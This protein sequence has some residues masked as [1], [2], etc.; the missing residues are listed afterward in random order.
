MIKVASILLPFFICNFSIL[1]AID[2][3]KNRFEWENV[4]NQISNEQKDKLEKCAEYLIKKDTLGYV[5]FGNKPV[6]MAGFFDPLTSHHSMFSPNIK[7]TVMT[8]IMIDILEEANLIGN[9]PNSNFLIQVQYKKFQDKKNTYSYVLFINKKAFIATVNKKLLLFQYVLGP[10]VTAEKLLEKVASPNE[11][12]FSALNNDVT[13][14]GIVLGYGSYNGCFGSYL[15]RI[16]KFLEH[17][18]ENLP[19]ISRKIIFTKKYQDKSKFFQKYN[20]KFMKQNIF[21]SFGYLSL[22]EE[23][24]D[25]VKRCI[26]SKT[27]SDQTE[28]NFPYFG[29]ELME[30]T[31]KIIKKY[32]KTQKDLQKVISSKNLLEMIFAR[33][34]GKDQLEVKE[35][36]QKKNQSI[37]YK[38]KKDYSD[39]LSQMFL[40]SFEKYFDN[41]KTFIQAFIDGL[42]MKE[43]EE[44]K[45]C[46]RIMNQKKISKQI[47]AKENLNFSDQ[48][49]EK[50]NKEGNSQEIVAK[51]LNYKILQTGQGKAITDTKNVVSVF[52][53]LSRIDKK[54][55]N[56]ENAIGVKIKEPLSNFMPGI[57][58]A[59]IGM[60]K[61]EKRKIFI[62]PSYGYGEKTTLDPNIAL[63]A[64]IELIDFEKDETIQENSI[65]PHLLKAEKFNLL[66]L[67]DNDRKN[68]IFSGNF[69]GRKNGEYIRKKN[70]N[71][72]LE[73]I[74]KNLQNPRKNKV[75]LE[76]DNIQMEI[77]NLYWLIYQD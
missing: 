16:D 51:K 23:Y 64:E 36:L 73:R 25:L 63:I 20:E 37:K 19:L 1:C 27:L 62:H 75:D 10:N 67:Q 44:S 42:K 14:V 9:N 52:Y 55:F 41:D 29:C 30:E 46:D 24:N 53:K 6:F 66:K 4:Y 72:S 26:I 68:T 61:N 35:G 7:E 22:K 33:F 59:L 17:N 12:L 65:E 48:F 28:P 32:K 77:R 56:A 54:P 43:S 70:S 18:N 57:A 31:D 11:T 47:K 45:I 5:L 38:E 58:K 76:N 49:F 34:A 71:F 3:K 60:K 8:R 13:L 40:Q 74:I 21:P 69:L 50:L 15:S 39:L 2:L